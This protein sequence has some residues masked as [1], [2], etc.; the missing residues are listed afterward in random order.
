MCCDNNHDRVAITHHPN[1][2]LR[3][4]QSAAHRASRHT[5]TNHLLPRMPTDWTHMA[6][7]RR[8]GQLAAEHLQ[9]AERLINGDR[10]DTY[11]DAMHDFRRVGQVWQA[12]LDLPEPLPAHTVAAMLAGLKLVRTQI[13]PDHMDSWDDG[14]AYC[15]L[16]A[17][18][19]RQT[20]DTDT[21][22]NSATA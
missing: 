8:T 7:S 20:H 21:T 22:N 4:P 19:V 17:G 2:W 3:L 16:G 9:R 11:G 14:A 12:L 10:H 5:T 1:H 13:T 18:I 6:R 15:G